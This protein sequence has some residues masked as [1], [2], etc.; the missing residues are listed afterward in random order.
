MDTVYYPVRGTTP[1]EW[2]QSAIVEAAR[3]GI[4]LP[5]VA[6]TAYAPRW[7]YTPRN[8]A[9]GC[10]PR[11]PVLILGIR[12]I[13]PRLADERGASSSDLSAWQARQRAL[14]RHEEGH[15]AL[16]LRSGKELRDSLRVLHAAECGLLNDR[17]NDVA[18]GIDAR[19]RMLQEV[20]DDRAR[21]GA[22]A[23][24]QIQ[25]FR[26]LSIAVDTTYRDSVP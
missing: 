1:L 26:G 4:M 7:T 25:R 17:I 24:E 21:H 2:S 3:V 19:Y 22:R 8:T 12:F 18:R 23:S 15:A 6:L 9:Y 14:W 10:E 11:E 5:T 13:M 16:A 20:Y